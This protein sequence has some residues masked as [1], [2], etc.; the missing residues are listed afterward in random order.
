MLQTYVDNV[1]KSC[2]THARLVLETIMEG[3]MNLKNKRYM[4]ASIV[5]VFVLAIACTSQFL[6]SS[7]Y[8]KVDP[9]TQVSSDKTSD[10][11]RL[12]GVAVALSDFDYVDLKESDLATVSTGVLTSEES[13]ILNGYN[14][15]AVATVEE[16]NLNI[17]E[18][19][20]TDSEIVGKMTDKNVCDIL[21]YEGEWAKITSGKVTGYVKSEF[22]I[23]GDEAYRIAKEEI[24]L[25]ACINTTTLRVRKEANTSSATVTLAGEGA[26]LKVTDT[27]NPE[28]IQVEVDD[29]L[30]YVFAEYVDT[31]ESLPTAKT[32]T[33]VKYGSGVS[34]V[35]VDLVSYALQFVGNPYV[36]GGTSLTRGADCSGFTMQIYA[37]YGIS[38]PHSS[39]A[40][41]GCGT[42]ISASEAQPGD[43]FFYGDGSY[44]SH[45]AIYIGGG[46]I[47]HASNERTGII[48]SSAYYR[49][50]IC[51]A[52]YL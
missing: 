48:V 29:E 23:T 10:G 3:K 7:V 31:Y 46:Q 9:D 43:L 2:Y 33:E 11:K 20:T 50:P 28:W 1:I 24:T 26:E 41:P 13:D 16:G 42:R 52:R 45:V 12:S 35:R 30:G 36:W 8:H 37:K 25:V 14:N 27:S 32:I 4:N 49:T 6:D 17:R 40:Q 21:E 19:A 5:L 15:I 47:V 34:D 51:V 38:L 39:R 44:I 18:S 22:L